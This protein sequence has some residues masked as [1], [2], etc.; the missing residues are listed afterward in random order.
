MSPVHPSNIMY[1]LQRYVFQVSRLCEFTT[2]CPHFLPP[3]LQTRAYLLVIYIRSEY[4]GAHNIYW[5]AVRILAVNATRPAIMNSQDDENVPTGFEDS[6]IDP[7]LTQ[8]HS[9]PPTRFY[10][11][12]NASLT[13]AV[14]VA[15]SVLVPGRGWLHTHVWVRFRR[16]VRA[17]RKTHLRCGSM[18]FI[19]AKHDT[20][21]ILAGRAPILASH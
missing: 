1:C 12:P 13:T 15:S 4:S 17:S 3:A 11:A 16:D 9:I 8:D 20:W 21:E 18:L 6:R 7:Q 2:S 14:A 19:V 10:G 5:L